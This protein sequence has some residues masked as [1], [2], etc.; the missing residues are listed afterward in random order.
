MLVLRLCTMIIDVHSELCSGFTGA[1]NFS[2]GQVRLNLTVRISYLQCISSQKLSKRKI[3]NKRKVSLHGNE[4]RQSL[5]NTAFKTGISNRSFLQSLLNANL[6]FSISCGPL[7][8]FGSK[9]Q[10][11]EYHDPGPENAARQ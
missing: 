3:K 6:T 2:N 1:Q 10:R 7:I 9:R 5:R 4:K 8:S 11:R